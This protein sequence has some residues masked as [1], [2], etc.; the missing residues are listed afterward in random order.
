M[1][2]SPQHPLH[3]FINPADDLQA[4]RV[5]RDALHKL[6]LVDLPEEQQT[7]GWDNISARLDSDGSEQSG[8]RGKRYGW[9][10]SEEWLGVAA[11][12]VLLVTVV[13]FP[14]SNQPGSSGAEPVAAE[15]YAQL[16]QWVKHSQ[17]LESQLRSLRAQAPSRVISGQRALAM[18]ELERMI[19]IVDL[20][21]AASQANRGET[22]DDD[23]LINE[24]TGLWQQRVVLL[25]E[26]LASQYGP[27]DYF[28]QNSDDLITTVNQQ[29]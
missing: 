5:L 24:R 7:A 28:D 27:A 20:Q 26:L 21:I 8:Q 10:R 11:A 25:N 23:L 4:R 13:F 18:D 14:H 2:K 29:I 15:K 3:D 19:G 1:N 9:L 17:L 16:Q 12:L 22:A 6:P